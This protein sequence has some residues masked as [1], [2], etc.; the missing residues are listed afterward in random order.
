MLQPWHAHPS[1]SLFNSVPI[2]EEP[3]YLPMHSVTFPVTARALR[4]DQ[5]LSEVNVNYSF[6]AV[7]RTC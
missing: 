5:R 7:S 6:L 1:A 4:F 3:V 2:K